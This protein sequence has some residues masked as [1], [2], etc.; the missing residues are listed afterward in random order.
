MK[1]LFYQFYIWTIGA[2]VAATIGLTAGGTGASAQGKTYVPSGHVYTPES[3]G[4][5]HPQSPLGQIE[6]QTDVY[7]SEIYQR[8]LE[9]YR[10]QKRF[11]LFIDHDFFSSRSITNY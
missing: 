6:A 8:Q 4:L 7:E 2:V 10:R 11:D 5:P 1:S 9:E 3:Q